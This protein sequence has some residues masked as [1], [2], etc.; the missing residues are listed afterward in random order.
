MWE[1]GKVIH[2]QIPQKENMPDRKPKK[3]SE[4]EVLKE[5]EAQLE[6]MKKAKENAEKKQESTE[7]LSVKSADIKPKA[8]KSTKLAKNKRPKKRS[9]KYLKTTQDFDKTKVYKLPDAL[10]WVKK[11]SYAKFDA[12]VELHLR[13]VRKKSQL[14]L[15]VMVEL[16]HGSGKKLKIVLL[17]Q[18]KIDAILKTKKID[19]DVA[20]AT[21]DMM[22]KIARIAKILGPKGKMP[23]PKSGT[24][25]TDPQKTI[26]EM[27]GGK[28]EVKE[29]NNGLVHQVIG[30][31]SWDD[32]KLLEN[33]SKIMAQVPRSQISSITLSATM[34]PGVKVKL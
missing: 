17:D 21:P 30:K 34:G 19:F 2:S 29:E 3:V 28:I 11:T 23:N 20:L 25:T 6:G 9:A 26:K 7:K 13:L 18:A 22:P 4:E 14:P 16:P 32:E 31:V 8:K 27:E 10:E 5:A 1:S 15:R 33:I 12:S 24:V